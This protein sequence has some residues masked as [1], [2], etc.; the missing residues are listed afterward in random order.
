MRELFRSVLVLWIEWNFQPQAVSGGSQRDQPPATACGYEF[1]GH[2]SRVIVIQ[3][4]S[5]EIRAVVAREES[6]RLHIEAVVAVPIEGADLTAAERKFAAALEAHHSQKARVLMAVPSSAIKWQYL[7][8]PPCPPEDLPALVTLQLDLESSRDEEAIGYDVLPF[9]GSEDKP[10]RVLGMIL[11]VADLAR[12]RNFTRIAGMKFEH[13]V[14]LA[15][16]WPALGEALSTPDS[17]TQVFM[18]VHNKEATIWAVNA[19]ELALLRQVQLAEALVSE[20]AGAGVAAQL[21]RTLLSLSQEGIAT[22]AAKI[23]LMGEPRLAVEKLGESLR[24]QFSQPIQTLKLPADV[25]IPDAGK[26]QPAELLPL[27]GI[28]WQ[29]ARSQPPRFDFLHPRKSPE[30]KSNRRTLV[31]GGVAAALLA[32]LIGW[33][34]YANLNEPLWTTEKLEGEL[35]TL[36]QELE[37]LE[38][39]Q[40]DAARIRDWLAASPNLLTELAAV[41]EDWRPQPLDSPEFSLPNDGVLKRFDLTNRRLVLTGNVAS[42]AAVQSLENRLRDNGH[43]VRREQSVPITDGGQY[44]WQVEIVVDVVDAGTAEGQP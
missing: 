20:S 7:S 5:H 29:A 37:P 35:A 32:A 40:R 24:R 10:Q 23:V 17:A 34:G 26:S 42:S 15:L 44:P 13:L 38:A 43:R 30:A 9:A 28:A 18:A 6:A 41:G 21:R 36:N 19:G 8:V 2:M 14:P 25:A 22:D 1:S 3:L 39:E 16:G 4:N 27:L 33:Q 12:V 11:K 31:L